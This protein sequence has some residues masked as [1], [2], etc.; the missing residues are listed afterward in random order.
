M[1]HRNERR[2]RPFPFLVLAIELLKF[3]P[4]PDD[5]ISRAHSPQPRVRTAEVVELHPPLNQHGVMHA[6]TPRPEHA[7]SQEQDEQDR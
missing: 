4:P 2:P 3:H 6:I 7:H 5:P 1:F